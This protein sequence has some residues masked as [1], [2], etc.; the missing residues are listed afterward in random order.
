[1]YLYKHKYLTNEHFKD[2]FY[3]MQLPLFFW[4]NVAYIIGIAFAFIFPILSYVLYIVTLGV[5]IK[6]YVKR[7]NHTAE[8][9]KEQ[10]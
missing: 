4:I 6:V 2:E 8:S 7:M 1:M 5:G 10:K 3:R 9:R